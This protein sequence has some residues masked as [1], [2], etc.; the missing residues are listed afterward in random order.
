MITKAY[1]YLSAGLVTFCVA[2]TMVSCSD[3]FEQESD[4]VMFDDQHRLDNATD[5]IYSVTGIMKKMQNLADRTIL[6]GEARGDLMEVTEAT[7]ADLRSVALFDISDD[8]KYNQ[9][10]D[11]YAVINNCNYFLANVD[12]LLRNSRNDT[13]FKR[14]YAAVKCFRAWTYLQLA[15]NYGQVPFITEPIMT[16]EQAEAL[17]SGT[18]RDLQYICDWLISDLTPIANDLYLQS[19]GEHPY[20]GDI[21]YRTNSSMF[22]FPVRVLLGELNLWGG[23]YKQAAEWYYR[24][25]S[26][27][28]GNNS[29]YPTGTDRVE[30]A[31]A[32]WTG[33]TSSWGSAFASEAYATEGELIT[34]IPGDSIP[35][36]GNYFE[37]RNVF[38]SSDAVTGEW[39]E[40]SLTPS[41]SLI[42]LSA[43]QTFC[44]YQGGDTIYA[45]ADIGFADYQTGD[46]RLYAAYNEGHTYHNNQRVT[47]QTIAKYRTRNA[48]IW[49]RQMVWLHMAEALNH[50]GYPRFAYQILAR[51]LSNKVIRSEVIPYYTADSTWIKTFDFPDTRYIA[52]SVTE[53]TG[54][55][56]MQGLH[57]RGSGL[58]YINKYYA[59]PNDTT[60]T[61]SLAQIAYQQ[62]L[63]DEMIADE[64]ALEFAFEGLRFYDLMRMALYRNEPAFLADRIYARRGSDNVDAVRGEIKVDLNEPRNWYLKWGG[65]IGY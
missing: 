25:I 55:P 29:T 27:R 41:Q 12:T 52:R 18:T 4:H 62:N 5:T 61:D 48:H 19:H 1:K 15:M 14:E 65:K 16:K 58:A 22:Y 53:I 2:A 6:L 31:N 24:Y 26:Q 3:F 46:L 57:S 64:G 37:L 40:V 13:I 23:H 59:M 11:Y 47:T 42:D 7:A 17:E 54:T 20:Y 36:N 39:H 51:G 49:R 35:Y 32:N 63:I 21:G 34:M 50:A 10:R 45:P 44:L 9:P 38:N 56:N 28:N 30:W 33:I 43:A 8:N 60:I